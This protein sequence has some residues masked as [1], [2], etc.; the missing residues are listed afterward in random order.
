MKQRSAH[1]FWIQCRKWSQALFLVGIVVV[2]C[3]FLCAQHP[4]YYP[5]NEENGLPTD[6]IY[7]FAQDRFGLIWVASNSGLFSYDGIRIHSFAHPREKTRAII[8]VTIDAHDRIWCRNSAGQVFKLTADSLQLMLDPDPA[9]PIRAIAFDPAGGFCTFVGN[10]ALRYDDDGRPRDSLVLSTEIR[11]DGS[12]LDA[13]M[14]NY[15]LFLFVSSIGAFELDF[16]TGRQNLLYKIDFFTTGGFNFK[17]E[18]LY[19]MLIHQQNQ[20]KE[21]LRFAAGKFESIYQTSPTE[22]PERWLR[23]VPASKDQLWVCTGN[24]A[25]PLQA[26]AKGWAKGSKRFHGI[27]MSSV[28]VDKEGIEWFSTLSEGFLVVPSP[29]ITRLVTETGDLKQNNFTSICALPDGNL[30]AGNYFGKLFRIDPEASIIQ[31]IF[32][33]ED[34]EGQFQ[35]RKI[36]YADPQ[37]LVSRGVISNIHFATQHIHRFPTLMHARDLAVTGENLYL[38]LPTGVRKFSYHGFLK[39]E[40]SLWETVHPQGGKAVEI[41]NAGNPYFAFNDGLYWREGGDMQEILL[42]G[43]KIFANILCATDDGIWAAAP[44]TGLI[45]MRDGEVQRVLG[46][47]EGLPSRNIRAMCRDQAQLFF[48]TDIHLC[49]FSLKTMQLTKLSA[50]IGFNP[51]H[52]NEMTVSNERIWLATTKGIVSLPLPL[53]SGLALA[54][55]IRIQQVL[56]DDKAIDFQNGLSIPNRNASLRIAFEGISFRSRNQFHFEYR[57]AAIDSAWSHTPAEANFVNY[58]SL[59]PGSFDFEVR[60]VDENGIRS[61]PSAVLHFDVATPFQQQPLFF[62]LLGLVVLLISFAIFQ[63]RLQYLGRR[64]RIQ[65]QLIHSQLT[66][67]KAQMNPH[68]MFNALN[69]IQDFVISRDVRNSNLY[70]TKFSTLMRMVLDASDRNQVRLSD[71]IEMLRLYLD[72]EQLRFGTELHYVVACSDGTDPDDIFLPSM[73]IQPF[74]ENAIKHGL[75]HKKGEKKLEI[76]FAVGNELICKILDNGVGRKRSA[77]IKARATKAH[78]SFSTAATVKRLVLIQSL[79]GMAV[80]LEITD[81]ETEGEARG[82]LVKLKLPIMNPTPRF[83]KS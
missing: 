29:E 22:D 14:H 34:N 19:L 17:G 23:I 57:I 81:L 55:P 31:E 58:A 76:T 4:L 26:N 56:L 10:K 36:L 42:N 48:S 79:Y 8:A 20:S 43:E 18:E 16:T 53:K 15:K 80:S 82:T 37:L 6:E 54:P 9:H 32:P 51:H 25:F 13:R 69:S 68:F 63:V 60:T 47:A 64:H 72:L 27:P 49:A 1:A 2:Q 38:V 7:E 33:N 52:I 11:I 5:I 44:A 61:D 83:V 59:Q 30:I 70:L 41:D 46:L 21:I 35:V 40:E 73:I 78:A 71:E 50:S 28:M 24:G 45:L 75:L 3:G 62:V 66:A 12:L 74:V 39:F 67:L 65:E 77:E